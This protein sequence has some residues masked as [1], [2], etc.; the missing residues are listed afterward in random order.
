MELLPNEV[1]VAPCVASLLFNLVS[2]KNAAQ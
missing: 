1:S 2:V